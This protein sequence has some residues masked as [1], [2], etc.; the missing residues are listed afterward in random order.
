MP[1]RS[2]QDALF[3]NPIDPAG[4]RQD[5]MDYFEFRNNV[6]LPGFHRLNL[7]LK[8][9]LIGNLSYQWDFGLYNA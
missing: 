1:S 5:G 7:S 6:W 8:G 9:R 4:E 2:L 3:I